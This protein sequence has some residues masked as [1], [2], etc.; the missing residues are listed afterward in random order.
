M[1]AAD[2][3]R[4][5][6][7]LAGWVPV[8]LA[9]RLEHP[10]AVQ[11]FLLDQAAVLRDEITVEPL[12]D[13]HYMVCGRRAYV[14]GNGLDIALAAFAAGAGGVP[15][16]SVYPTGTR[17]D[18]RALA[19]LRR[20]AATLERAHP[21]LA[22]ELYAIEHHRGRLYARDGARVRCIGVAIPQGDAA[23]A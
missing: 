11:T 15:V 12:G 5:L 10:E 19:A 21:A 18:T 3:A 20:A 2:L 17:P 6:R 23:A 22:A 9:Q 8:V 1:N 7:R 14:G 4:D 16:S 13:G